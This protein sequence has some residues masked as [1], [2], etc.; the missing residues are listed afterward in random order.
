[1]NA[2]VINTP[3]PGTSR[4]SQNKAIG[5]ATPSINRNIQTSATT[6]INNGTVTTSPVRNLR[7][8]HPI[9]FV[10]RVVRLACAGGSHIPPLRARQQPNHRDRGEREPVIRK[11]LERMPREVTDKKLHREVADHGR[12]HD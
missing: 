9:P 11:H 4:P 8:S 5:R 1:M 10:E 3:S 7:L 6:V 2:A 12:R